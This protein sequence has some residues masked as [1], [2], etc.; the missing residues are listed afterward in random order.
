VSRADGLELALRPGGLA[1]LEADLVVSPETP[2]FTGHFTGHP[3]LPAIAQLTVA[4]R[5]HRAA[6][7]RGNLA[8]VEAMRFGSLV[9]PGDRLVARLTTDAES[10]RSNFRLERADGG[11]VSSGRLRWGS[12]S[13]DQVPDAQEDDAAGEPL[14]I[15]LPHTGPSRLLAEV[16]ARGPGKIE[17]VG[18][19]PADHAAADDGS[20]PALVAIEL[21]AQAAAQIPDGR[22][23]EERPEAIAGGGDPE[24]GL[25]Y[26]VRLRDVHFAR[27]DLP[28]AQA[29]VA[30]LDLA[31]RTGPLTR[32]DFVVV[33]PGGEP[34]AAGSLTTW[35][36]GES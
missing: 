29:L 35:A 17:A 33:L 32:F 1:D 22:R 23:P 16:V 7:G 5:L 27:V 19:I 13:A 18:R 2:W 24:V 11:E 25:G 26:L 15:A 9:G 31:G 10:G 14:P 34:L 30:H 6:G 20:A 28:V 8:A 3:V 21:A 36:V 4:L 12:P